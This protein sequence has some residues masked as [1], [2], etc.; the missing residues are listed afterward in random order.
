MCFGRVPLVNSI[1]IVASEEF[2]FRFYGHTIVLLTNIPMQY[3]MY[4]MFLTYYYIII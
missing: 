1:Y 2:Q 4:V 3:I